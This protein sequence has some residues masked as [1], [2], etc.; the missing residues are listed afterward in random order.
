MPIAPPRSKRRNTTEINYAKVKSKDASP[1][2]NASAATQ[3]QQKH[4][5]QLLRKVCS[6][7]EP[8]PAIP[9]KTKDAFELPDE[10]GIKGN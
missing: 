7:S 4:M 3:D 6:T 9:L 8:P 5:S 2:T 10:F 1:F